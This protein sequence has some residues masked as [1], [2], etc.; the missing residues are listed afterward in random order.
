MRQPNKRIIGLFLISGFVLIFVMLLFFFGH[1]FERNAAT[2]VLFFE[3]S[4]KG[5]NVG[6]N[7]YFRGVPIGHVDKIQL[8]PNSEDKIII[9]EE[10]KKRDEKNEV[11]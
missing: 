6:A 1:R 4:V 7:V 5:L 9:P 10:I 3:G 11:F 8:I 2:P